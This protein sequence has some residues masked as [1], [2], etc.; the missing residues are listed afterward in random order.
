VIEGAD[1]ELFNRG[2]RHATTTLS[3]EA[4]DA[5]L[6]EL[7]WNDALEEDRRVAVS[8]L[9]ESQGSANAASSALDRVLTTALGFDEGRLDRGHGTFGVVLPQ[10]G[11]REA[12]GQHEG[13]HCAVNGLATSVVQRCNVVLVVTDVGG[14]HAAVVVDTALLNLRTVMAL[15]PRLQLVEVRGDLN[16]ANAVTQEPIDWA[17]AVALGQ[18]A[19]GHELVGAARAMLGLARQHALERVQF[20]TTISSFQAVRHRLADC[21]VAVEAADALLSASWDDPLLNASMAKS[22]A[23]RSARAVARHCQQVL[24][25]TGF[26]T[27]HPFHHY[28]RRITVLDLILGAGNSMTRE[29]GAEILRTAQL[30]PALPL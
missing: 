4:L 27:E 18:L 7:G 3:G 10:L 29:L 12:P 19:L 8:L 24:A 21:L 20:G 17:S 13:A 26:T 16:I 11:R 23:G 5:A 25:G 9:F 28:L 14:H 15:D 2:L 6:A 22:F 1:L 30:P